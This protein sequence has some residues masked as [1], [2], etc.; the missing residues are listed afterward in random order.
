MVGFLFFCGVC[1]VFLFLDCWEG[2]MLGRGVGLGVFFVG[3]E[4]V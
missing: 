2:W 1:W 3:L 4:C